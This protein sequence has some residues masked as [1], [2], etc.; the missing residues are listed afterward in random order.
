MVL[1]QI[2]IRSVSPAVSECGL[3]QS[4]QAMEKWIEKSNLNGQG[5]KL[6]MSKFVTTL[7][8]DISNIYNSLLYI[9]CLRC[10]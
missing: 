3:K 5:F 7:R 2:K 10:H 6:I 9:I 4:K 8:Y 1:K